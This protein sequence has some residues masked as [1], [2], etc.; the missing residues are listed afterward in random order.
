MWKKGYNAC[1]RVA[2]PLVGVRPIDTSCTFAQAERSTRPDDGIYQTYQTD[3]IWHAKATPQL[4]ESP[5]LTRSSLH[6]RSSLMHQQ[7]SVNQNTR[8]YALQM[9]NCSTW[10]WEACSLMQASCSEQPLILVFPSWQRK[11]QQ[12]CQN[13]LKDPSL[14]GCF[15]HLYACWLCWYLPKKHRT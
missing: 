4:N 10:L 1:S 12:I 13:D 5:R 8:D 6:V 3:R 11:I 9:E 7:N 14:T 15:E 2:A